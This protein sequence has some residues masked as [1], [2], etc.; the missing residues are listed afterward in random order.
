[1]RAFFQGTQDK[2]SPTP[3]TR[4][5]PSP[6]TAVTLLR[7]AAILFALSAGCALVAAYGA[8]QRG[9]HAATYIKQAV[10]YV[11]LCVVFISVAHMRKRRAT[12]SGEEKAPPQ[13]K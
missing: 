12:Q 1:V 6:K 7:I 8:H 4:I 2:L 5:M 11:S 10:M 13:S 3:F 9:E